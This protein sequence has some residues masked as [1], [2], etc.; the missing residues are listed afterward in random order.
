MSGEGKTAKLSR[1]GGRGGPAGV[2]R[3]ARKGR[4]TAGQEPGTCRLTAPARQGK[5]GGGSAAARRQWG[6]RMAGSG[7]PAESNAGASAARGT[8]QP[9]GPS[10]ASYRLG[11]VSAQQPGR[12]GPSRGESGRPASGLVRVSPCSSKGGRGSLASRA[13]GAPR[14]RGR[15]RGMSPQAHSGAATI[16]AAAATTAVSTAG[17]P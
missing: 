3:G 5:E 11:L 9:P 16:A 15:K 8:R 1:G 2:S 17:Q 4:G 12:P 6:Q 10:A 7:T 13:R 14:K